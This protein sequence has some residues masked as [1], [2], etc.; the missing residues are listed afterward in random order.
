MKSPVLGIIEVILINR[1]RLREFISLLLIFS[2]MFSTVACSSTV[3]NTTLSD[4]NSQTTVENVETENIITETVLTEFITSEIY[5]EEMIIAEEKISELLLEEETITEVMLCKSIYVPQD[6]IDE[7]AAN[8]QAAQLFGDEVDI[9]A[10]LKKVAV[11]TGVIVTVVVLEKAGLSDLIA[12]VVFSAADESLKSSGKETVIGSLFEGLIGAADEIDESGRASAVISFATATVGL[13][14]S[15][16]SLVA[17]GPSGGSTTITTAA[18]VK[19]VIAA[20]S[21]LAAMKE[22]AD[23]GRQAV[24]TFTSTD[25][26]DIDWDNIDWQKVGVSSVEKTIENAADEYM[27]GAIIGVVHGGAEGYD[28]YQ[29]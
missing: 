26:T 2:I 5:L 1:N 10:L 25:S 16:V 4:P 24:K 14:L 27:W 15:I 21:M 3:P 28:F 12:S 9:S 17:E 23:A 8:D 20:V 6:K 7:F 22:T 19:L 13:I 11:G 29:K 18:G